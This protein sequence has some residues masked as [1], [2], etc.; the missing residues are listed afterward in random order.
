MQEKIEKIIILIIHMCF[1]F[2]SSIRIEFFSFSIRIC[3]PFLIMFVF[4]FSC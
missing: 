4:L 3:F 1:S 2:P